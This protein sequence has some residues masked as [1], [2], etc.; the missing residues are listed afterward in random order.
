MIS[1]IRSF[2]IREKSGVAAIEFGFLAP[3]FF[4]LMIAIFEICYFVYMSTSTQRA[5]E[6]AVFDLRTN[7]AATV[8]QQRNLTVEQWYREA[9]CGRIGMTTCEDTLQ[10]TIERYDQDM[11]RAWSTSDPSQLT[12]APRE[13]VMRVE[14]V[15]EMPTVMFTNLLF[16]DNAARLTSGITFMTEP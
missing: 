8:V 1:R 15:V 6:K 14:A 3:A 11:N 9:I 12:L 10:V 7:Y 16:G 5:V 13:T 2:V 4:T